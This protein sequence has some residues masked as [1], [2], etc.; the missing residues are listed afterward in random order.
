MELKDNKGN[1]IKE[2]DTLHVWNDKP[3]DTHLYRDYE[4][5]VVKNDMDVLCVRYEGYGA[6]IDTPITEYE[7]KYREVVKGKAKAVK[8]DE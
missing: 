8:A 2:G 1:I 6:V 7:E 5:E 3:K 4:G